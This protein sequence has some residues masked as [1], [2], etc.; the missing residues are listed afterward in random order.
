MNI[1]EETS[2][3]S[4]DSS[5]PNHST[6]GIMKT[7]I[8][9]ALMAM[10]MLALTGCANKNKHQ[11]RET[12]LKHIKAGSR[13]G[14][15]V[16]II[17]VSKPDSTFGIMY[18]TPKEMQYIN[19][20]IEDNTEYLLNS[21]KDAFDPT[22]KDVQLIDLMNRQMQ[23]STYITELMARTQLRDKFNGWKIHAAFEEKLNGYIFKTEKWFFFDKDGEIIYKTFEIPIP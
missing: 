15:E 3:P 23:A 17:S 8:I 21:D 19:N 6:T 11:M 14:S 4:Q 2:M 16:N 9:L 7:R 1:P 13:I 20:K 22:N 12:V 5:N 10:T 18:L